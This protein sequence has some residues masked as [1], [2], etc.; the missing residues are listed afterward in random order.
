MSKSL[1]ALSQAAELDLC[2]GTTVCVSAN[3]IHSRLNSEDFLLLL[4]L[5][6]S[7]M[8]SRAFLDSE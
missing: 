2:S 7:C 3:G 1:S 4:F 5:L 8:S 6:F